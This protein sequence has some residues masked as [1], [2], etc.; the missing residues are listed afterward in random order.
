MRSDTVARLMLAKLGDRDAALAITEA[1]RRSTA[2]T[3]LQ[4]V[5]RRWR[6]RHLMRHTA[7]PLWPLLRARLA[8]ASSWGAVAE[9][10][11]Y[12]QVRLEW[13]REPGCWMADRSARKARGTI[14]TILNECR[15]GHWGACCVATSPPP[16]P[17]PSIHQLLLVEN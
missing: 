5:V 1:W 15:Q 12:Q 3:L 14:A 2:V 16:P 13:S 10:A 7:H 17:P 9:L 4:A 8:A 11:R 6:C